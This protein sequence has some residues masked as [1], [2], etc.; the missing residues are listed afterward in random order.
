MGEFEVKT[1][2]AQTYGF[3]TDPNRFAPLLPMFKEL[4]DVQDDRF[5]IVMD[6]GMPQI[7]GRA[8]ANVQFVERQ[9]DQRA[10][11]KSTVRHSLGMADSNMSFDLSASDHGTLVSWN[12]S[13]TVRGTLASLA[14]GILAP[15]ARKNVDAMIASV[16][17]EL[18]D[19]QIGAPVPFIDPVTP[20]GSVTPQPMAKRPSGWW[21]RLRGWFSRLGGAK[22]LS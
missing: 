6:V 4:A 5:R 3:L 22:G 16:R 20:N 17:N 12:C 10:V 13:T 15:L 19:A 8:E 11:L 14:S 21:L 2:P 18:G 9:P 7:R 1:S